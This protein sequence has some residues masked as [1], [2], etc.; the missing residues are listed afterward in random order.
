MDYVSLCVFNLMPILLLMILNF[1]IIRTLKKV[2]N[3]DSERRRDSGDT[4]TPIVGFVSVRRIN[5]ITPLLRNQI[6]N[7]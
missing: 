5:L 1:R 3:Q 4:N 2:A 7:D 6:H